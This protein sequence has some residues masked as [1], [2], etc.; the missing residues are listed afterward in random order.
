MATKKYR[1]LTTAFNNKRNEAEVRR[2][3][4][5]FLLAL[6]SY[7]ER[8]ASDPCLSFEEY[9]FSILAAD[10]ALKGGPYRVN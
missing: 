7:P 8:F 9:L 3:I 5:N 4:D 1:P 10:Q 2:E 6:N